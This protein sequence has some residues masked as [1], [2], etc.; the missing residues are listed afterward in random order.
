MFLNLESFI[1]TIAEEI[2]FSNRLELIIQNAK[3]RSF[4]DDTKPKNINRN[5]CL[6]EKKRKKNSFDC[7]DSNA[8]EVFSRSFTMYQCSNTLF[9]FSEKYT[10]LAL[11]DEIEGES[12]KQKQSKSN[13]K[14]IN[15]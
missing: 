4:L 1:F 12:Q 7:N 14:S 15:L 6:I 2:P 5:D 9:N 8:F 10:K 13:T 11:G 3:H